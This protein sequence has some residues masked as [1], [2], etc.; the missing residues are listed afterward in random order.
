MLD[1]SVISVQRSAVKTGAKSWWFFF[2]RTGLW[3][4]LGVV[5]YSPF[6]THPNTSLLVSST[7]KNPIA[8]TCIQITSHRYTSC[9]NTSLPLSS[10]EK[11]SNRQYVHSDNQP[12]VHELSKH[13]VTTTINRKDSNRQYVHTDNQPPLHE[14]SPFW[15]QTRLAI[16]GYTEG[17]GMAQWVERRTEKPVATLIQVRV[18][19]AARD[20]S[21]SVSFQCRL[22]LRCPYSP[23]VQSRASTSERTLKILNTGSHWRVGE[24]IPGYGLRSL[25]RTVYSK[26]FGMVACRPI[27]K[28]T[29]NLLSIH[30]WSSRQLEAKYI[31]IAP[32]KL[33]KSFMTIVLGWPRAVNRTLKSNSCLLLWTRTATP[34]GSRPCLGNVMVKPRTSECPDGAK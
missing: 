3:F 1:T 11:N 6:T 29:I 13:I 8:K 26:H 25:C 32:N 4:C 5:Y 10:T 14:F 2:P 33:H 27:V 9:P 16:W 12:P 15:T 24:Y 34:P 28:Q 30:S 20:F 18:P 7:E 21:P 23:R 17:A 22:S 31:I 19:G